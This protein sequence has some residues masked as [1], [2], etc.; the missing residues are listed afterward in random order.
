MLA[1][2]RNV[3]ARGCAIA[4]KKM[5][6]STPRPIGIVMHASPSVQIGVDVSGAI[7]TEDLMRGSALEK[8]GAAP[9]MPVIVKAVPNTGFVHSVVLL[10]LAVLA[11]IYRMLVQCVLLRLQCLATFAS[12]HVSK[13]ELEQTQFSCP[14]C[15]K[16]TPSKNQC[17]QLQDLDKVNKCKNCKVNVKVRDWMCSCGH[18]WHLCDIHR[19]YCSQQSNKKP[20][21][22]VPSQCRKRMLGPLTHEQLQEIDTKRMRRTNQHVLPPAPNILSAKLRERFAYLF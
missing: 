2:A 17:F 16:E 11:V 8:S 19:S 21:S 7:A 22:N 20:L 5:P 13:R 9:H 14:Q 18:T 3:R 15:N 12:N 1:I 4:V 6:R 10:W